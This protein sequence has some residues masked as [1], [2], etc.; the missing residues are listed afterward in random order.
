MRGGWIFQKIFHASFFN[1]NLSNILY[2][3]IVY[4]IY[5]EQR[6]SQVLKITLECIVSAPIH[7]Q[8]PPP[9][10]SIL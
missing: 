10:P 8:A 1:E 4:F 9:R 7:A 6:D 5:W 3:Y 2:I